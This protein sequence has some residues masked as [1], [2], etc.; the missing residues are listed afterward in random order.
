MLEKNL[1]SVK[2]QCIN[3]PQL[4]EE[5]M[6]TQMSILSTKSRI[7][8]GQSDNQPDSRLGSSMVTLLWSD[9]RLADG[10][11]TQKKGWEIKV[12]KA[13]NVEAGEI[14]G[15]VS[16][17]GRETLA[18][19]V[20]ENPAG[21]PPSMGDPKRDTKLDY[22]LGSSQC[23]SYACQSSSC[24]SSGCSSYGCSSRSCVNYTM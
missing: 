16:A 3:N 7:V 15:V 20:A 14:T 24:Q 4:K 19:M 23:S 10:F 11:L 6:N 1:I 5:K 22:M 9:A 12:A 8:I 18:K 13:L 17:M 21:A 2:S